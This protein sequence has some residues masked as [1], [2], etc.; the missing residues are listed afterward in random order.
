M[1]QLAT[2]GDPSN[3]ARIQHLYRHDLA[4]L[5]RD[6]RGRRYDD[7]ATRRAIAEVDREHDYLMDPHTAVGYLAL[8]DELAGEAAGTVGV[9]LATAHPAKFREVVEPVIG[10][11]IELPPQLASRLGKPVL[12]EELANDVAELKRRLL[13]WE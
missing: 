5:R 7:Q 8:R 11:E 1:G 9:V 12:S 6:L 4:A 10:R 13:D 3:F 2:D